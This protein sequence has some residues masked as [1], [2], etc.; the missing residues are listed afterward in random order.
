VELG[1]IETW[2]EDQRQAAFDEV[3]Q[4][5][6]CAFVRRYTNSMSGRSAIRASTAWCAPCGSFQ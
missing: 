2:V 3:R 1:L 5:A 4:S 6:V